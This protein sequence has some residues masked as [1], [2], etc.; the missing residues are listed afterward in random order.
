MKVAQLLVGPFDQ[1]LQVHHLNPTATKFQ[2]AIAF[3]RFEGNRG[4]WTAY[5][6]A[7]R[8]LFMRCNNDGTPV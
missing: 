8:Y 4:F 5:A 2:N 3:Q 1:P 6:T 7:G